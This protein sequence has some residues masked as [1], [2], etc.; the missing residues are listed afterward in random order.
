MCQK[1]I[2]NVLGRLIFVGLLFQV[3]NK[4]LMCVFILSLR[5]IFIFANL[6]FKNS[7][8]HSKKASS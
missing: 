4:K 7:I 8:H 6:K 2:A 1:K 3:K 5:K